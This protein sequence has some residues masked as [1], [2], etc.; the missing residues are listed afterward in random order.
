[1]LSG[2][3]SLVV[4]DVARAIA[5]SRSALML[6]AGISMGRR[7][8][9]PDWKTMVCKLIREIAIETT[10][11][12]NLHIKRHLG[13]LFNE[14]FFQIMFQTLGEE[15]TH[16]AISACL[17]AQFSSSIHR[18]VA[19]CGHRFQ[20][21]ILTTNFD[22]LIEESAPSVA[23]LAILKLHGTLSQPETMRFR[24]NSVYAPLENSL[25]QEIAGYLNDRVLVV[26]GYSGLDFHDVMPALFH[27][28]ARPEKV[29]WI[30]HSGED[31]DQSVQSKF[32]K[33]SSIEVID[34]DTD[35]FFRAVAETLQHML[36][37]DR[38]D[39][40]EFEWT[41]NEVCPELDWWNRNCELWA[42]SLRGQNSHRLR[43][44]WARLANHLR[45][46]KVIVQPGN[47][48][49]HLA[50]EAYELLKGCHDESTRLE[51]RVQA[52]YMTRM[53]DENKQASAALDAIIA[54]IDAGA[55][56]CPETERFL[57]LALHHAGA[58]RQRLK[59]FEEAEAKFVRAI[60]VRSQVDQNQLPYSEFGRYMNARVAFQHGVIV[61]PFFVELNWQMEYAGRIVKQ[62]Q[63]A[64][65]GYLMADYGIWLHN[66][67]FV[68]QTMAEDARSQ[69]QPNARLVELATLA[70]GHYSEAAEI[71]EQTRDPRMIAQSLVRKA[72]IYLFLA[73]RQRFVG[74]SRPD[75]FLECR[76]LLDL[77]QATVDKLN[78]VNVDIA[79]E[80][81]PRTHILELQQGLNDFEKF[82][83]PASLS[84]W[85]P[86]G[87]IETVE[88][89]DSEA[90]QI[91]DDPSRGWHLAVVTAVV[92]RHNRV[93]MTKLGDYAKKRF[94]DYA[95]V[96]PGGSVEPD[97]SPS[98]AAV[99][100]LQEETGLV[101][102]P[103]QLQ[104]VAWICRPNL[105]PGHRDR[106]GELLLLFGSQLDLDAPK[107]GC[108]PPETI[109]SSW[110]EVNLEET[111]AKKLQQRYDGCFPAH[112]LYWA[113]LAQAEIITRGST[114]RFLFYYDDM[115]FK[116]WLKIES[117]QFEIEWL[118][119]SKSS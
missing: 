111:Q 109:A 34:V 79:E 49:R 106:Q 43:L 84:N 36:R 24:V 45:L 64:K 112:H 31:L 32:I 110:I 101:L 69:G 83:F 107:V 59:K 98:Q 16:G 39:P 95:W 48:P 23:K 100:E 42:Q 12:A 74:S 19:A 37:S 87:A 65:N 47:E 67:A 2:E 25:R 62:L 17:D 35:K 73:T 78:D 68:Y 44:L 11:D 91:R 30:N 46:Y 118:F 9:C 94:G 18:F 85:F 75:Q 13:L 108:A 113:R 55:Y 103:D 41:E 81:T 63:D 56:G 22:E 8:G 93:L 60:E 70:L 20:T 96:L 3:L 53:G 82:H 33:P 76:R 21:R 117:V 10:P 15:G 38:S 52:A 1:M 27:Q 89:V 66:L 14:T 61:Q 50:D 29:Y 72:Q 77:A 90:L 104:P 80:E 86:V 28:S 105:V 40:W 115:S 6:G 114:P 99:R 71:R 57:G 4:E 54:E 7:S 102:A 119:S 51:A 5:E 26:A 97:E 116:P 88:Q 58:A 92:D